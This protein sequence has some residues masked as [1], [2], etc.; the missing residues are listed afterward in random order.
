L[1]TVSDVVLEVAGLSAVVGA[2]P[3]ASLSVAAPVV[4]DVDVDSAG[5]PVSPDTVAFV[6]G[7]S[8]EPAEPEFELAELAE[9][10]VADPAEV[11]SAAATP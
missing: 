6:A 4:D 5:L 11:S 1:A 2:M 7:V 8:G 3:A 9:L 10:D